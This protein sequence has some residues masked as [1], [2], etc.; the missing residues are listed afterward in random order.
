MVEAKADELE[1]DLEK[2]HEKIDE[3]GADLKEAREELDVVKDELNSVRETLELI[4]ELAALAYPANAAEVDYLLRN[5]K[6]T[7]IATDLRAVQV[8]CPTSDEDVVRA[9]EKLSEETK[10]L[11][12]N[13]IEH[14][15]K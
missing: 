5:V 14:V 12:F 4:P 6:L 3:L 11:V 9:W 15:E 10:S 13:L 2:A 7:E 8:C 1:I